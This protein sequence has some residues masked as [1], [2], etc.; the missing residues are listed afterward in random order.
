M[1]TE[2]RRAFT[3]IELL[4]VIAIIAILAAMLLPALAKAKA[5]A[6][7]IAC[8]NNLKQIDLGLRMWAGDQGDKYPWQIDVTQGGSLNSP[9]WTDNFRAASA[10]LGNWK[11]L[12]CP[13]DTVRLAKPTAK[14]WGTLRG[15]I[16]VS[17]FVG[18]GTNTTVQNKNIVVL[19]GDANFTGG[20][21]GLD[22]FW[23]SYMGTSIDAGWENSLHALKGNIGTLDG[24][25]RKIDTPSLRDNIS[26][27]IASG[28]DPVIF[29]K[30]RGA[31]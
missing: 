3:L 23:N 9:D 2:H 5:R 29:S 28:V 4:V 8:V 22:A 7:D 31:F 17:Y 12:L 20:G 26:L 14:S 16:N 15:D 13:A 11:V 21:G 19:L 25:A 24:T 6:R 10:P 18:I 30:P 27:E 1:K